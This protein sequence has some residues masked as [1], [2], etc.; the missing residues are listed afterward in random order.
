[1]K[2][3]GWLSIALLTLFLATLFLPRV[4]I[5]G[6]RYVDTADKVNQHLQKVEEEDGEEA[7]S[8]GAVSAAAL[9]VDEFSVDETRDN[10]IR[11]FD[12]KIDE[13]LDSRSMMD[14]FFGK[15]ALTVKDTLYFDGAVFRAD[16]KIEDSGVQS[17]FKIMGVLIY[18]PVLFAVFVLILSILNKQ[19]NGWLLTALGAVTGLAELFWYLFMPG[20]IWSKVE[21]YV[22]GF[23]S[24]SAEVLHSDGMGEYAVSGMVSGFTAWG[25]M[26]RI[27]F[28]VF[29]LVLGVLLLTVF[30]QRSIAFDQEMPEFMSAGP[31]GRMSVEN[32]GGFAGPVPDQPTVPMPGSFPDMSVPPQN[33]A[34]SAAYGYTTGMIRCTAGQFRRS[35]FEVRSGEEFVI[36]RDPQTCQLVLQYPKISRRHCGITMDAESGNYL[37]IDY[38]SNGT[39][40]STG[41][42]V[43][44]THYQQVLPGTTLYLATEKEAFLLE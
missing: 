17:V 23:T 44:K 6:E 28:A 1:M 30:R 16:K 21:E 35:E 34:A 8:A 33:A 43:S 40:L 20:M 12:E 5:S 4:E 38:S 11:E 18:L 2:W 15:W 39:R 25:P 32:A 22:D 14:L 3:Q 10:R 36:G 29:F 26:V 9:V 42:M 31:A 13:K 24:I 37:V 41:G 19:A 27:V 7:V